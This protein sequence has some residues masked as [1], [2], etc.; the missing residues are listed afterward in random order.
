M[1]TT[2]YLF[3]LLKYVITSDIVAATNSLIEIIKEARTDGPN[4]GKLLKTPL[5]LLEKDC[6]NHAL[7]VAVESG[8]PTNVAMLVN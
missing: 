3:L 7:L 6:M 4:L 8:N 1:N 2:F 5:N